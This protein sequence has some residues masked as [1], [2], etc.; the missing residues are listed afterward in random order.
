MYNPAVRATMWPSLPTITSLIVLAP[1][2][3]V[4]LLKGLSVLSAIYSCKVIST[5]AFPS[6]QAFHQHD[7]PGEILIS[8]DQIL[9]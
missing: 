9:V 4:V 3:P 8:W 6:A 7:I 2:S 5:I 1:V